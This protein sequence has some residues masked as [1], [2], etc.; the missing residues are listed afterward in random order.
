MDIAEDLLTF[1]MITC[2]SSTYDFCNESFYIYNFGE[3]ITGG[4]TITLKQMRQYAQQGDTLKHLDHFLASHGWQEKCKA[5]RNWV[6]ENFVD[7]AVYNWL[8]GIGLSQAAEAFDIIVPHFQTEDILRCCIKGFNEWGI[9]S[10]K[11]AERLKGSNIFS[12]HKREI[13]TIATY[14]FRICDGGV[15]RVM[16]QL[17]EIWKNMGY[18]VLIITDE[19]PNKYDYCYPESAIRISLSDMLPND[20]DTMACRILNLHKIMKDYEVDL[21]VYHAWCSPNLLWDILAVK[22]AGT[23]FLVHTH[24]L[25]SQGYRSGDIH[26]PIQTALLGKYFELADGLITLSDVDTAW[27]KLWHPCVFHSINPVTWEYEELPPEEPQN[28]NILW[29]ARISQEKQPLLALQIMRIVLRSVPD[30]ILHVVGKASDSSYYQQFL[31]E[32]D[33]LELTDSII[34]H[35]F[36][37]N[38][39]QYYEACR[40]YLSTSEYEGQPLTMVESKIMARPCVTFNLANLDMVREGKGMIVV[41]QGD[42][43]ASAEAVIKLLQD[44]LLWQKLSREAHQSARP[45]CEYN[46]YDAWKNIIDTISLRT[47]VPKKSSV[48]IAVHMQTQDL[49]TCFDLLGHE[50]KYYREAFEWN[51]KQSEYFQHE[52]AY[53]MERSK[54]LEQQLTTHI[55]PSRNSFIL[56]KKIKT[57]F[58][59]LKEYGIKETIKIVKDKI[60]KLF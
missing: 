51:I 25:F 15:E 24:S 16:A 27:W 36:Q 57:L 55:Q 13:K 33:R 22:M 5:A 44:P 18:R 49:L 43:N 17:A 37:T 6:S 21:F 30:A 38:V 9:D 19:S 50:I 23:A 32:I 4:K 12:P 42:I 8:L 47:N 60:Q 7:A 58:R 54:Y 48:N 26:Y 53:Y 40:V 2:F 3:G 56:A 10:L 14:Y 59:C 11:I 39:R 45:I 20:S 46:Q 1:F 29:L 35:G 52:L 31:D 28:H 41:P 34:L